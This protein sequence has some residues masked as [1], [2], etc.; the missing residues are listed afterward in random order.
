VFCPIIRGTLIAA[1]IPGRGVQRSNASEIGRVSTEPRH[2][3]LNQPQSCARSEQLP[4]SQAPT[5]PGLDATL[6][7]SL[8]WLQTE[9]RTLLAEPVLLWHLNGCGLTWYESTRPPR[10]ETFPESATYTEHTIWLSD[11]EDPTHLRAPRLEVIDGYQSGYWYVWV[12]PFGDVYIRYRLRS[13]DQPV[14][15]HDD[16]NPYLEVKVPTDYLPGVRTQADAERL[17]AAVTQAGRLCH[18]G[19]FHNAHDR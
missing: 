2:V 1:N 19:Q 5:P 7:Q 11:I 13:L 6:N 8:A 12:K 4:P 9:G 18:A 3:P 17:R 14:P 15:L 10:L 16:R